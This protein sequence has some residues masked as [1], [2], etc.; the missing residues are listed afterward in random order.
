[1][2]ETSLLEKLEQIGSLRERV[3]RGH[4]LQALECAIGYKVPGWFRILLEFTEFENSYWV[5]NKQL[6]EELFV[7]VVGSIIAEIESG[8]ESGQAI[9]SGY[10]PLG[11]CAAGTGELFVAQNNGDLQLPIVRLSDP[12]V[13]MFPSPA[14]LFFS[15]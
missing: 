11:A 12:G 7:P 14:N 15:I 3:D 1:M 2:N 6:D 9:S 13:S 4:S 10:F 8:G 5:L